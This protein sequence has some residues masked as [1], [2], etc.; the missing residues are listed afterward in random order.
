MLYQ[1]VHVD[2][3]NTDNEHRITQFL[4]FS[5]KTVVC[6]KEGSSE[7]FIFQTYKKTTEC[8]AVRKK[9]A[10]ILTRVQQILIMEVPIFLIVV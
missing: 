4:D 7:A 10:V 6:T 9:R 8:G 3:V 1:E 5:R 2:L